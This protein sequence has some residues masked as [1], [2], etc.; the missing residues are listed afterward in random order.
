MYANFLQVFLYDLLLGVSA[1][2]TSVLGYSV[3]WALKTMSAM[4]RCSLLSV[5]YLE[6]FL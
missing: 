3:N 2:E 4:E 6:V 5:C 1:L